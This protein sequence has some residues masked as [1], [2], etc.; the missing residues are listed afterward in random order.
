MREVETLQKEVWQSDDRDVVPVSILAATLEVGAIL[1]GAFDGPALVGFAYSFVGR[2]RERLVHHSHMLAVIPSHRNLNLGYRLKLAQ[3]DRALAQGIDTMTWTF[4]PLQSVNAHLNFAKLGVIADTY[5]V[6]FYGQSTSGFLLQIGMGTDR[7][8]VTWL[9][10]SERVVGKLLKQDCGGVSRAELEGI[11][12]LVRVAPKNTPQLTTS[13]DVFSQKY[14][15]IEIPEDI[16]SL[17]RENPTLAAQWRETTR[18]AFSKAFAAGYLVE[19]F[20]GSTRND[21]PLGAYLLSRRDA[22]TDSN[23]IGFQV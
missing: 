13:T 8:W 21:Y 18:D 19:D 9:L 17:Q 3:R 14:F 20:F 22:S 16:N 6:N 2:E 1:L 11:S 7:L 23:G 12:C 15:A 5:K 10:N 4:D